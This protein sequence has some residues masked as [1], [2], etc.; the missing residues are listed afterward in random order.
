MF[1]IFFLQVI[2]KIVLKW[3]G[4]I[5][6]MYKCFCHCLFI[7]ATNC[8]NLKFEIEQSP[9]SPYRGL[10]TPTFHASWPALDDFI[11]YIHNTVSK[12][13]RLSCREPSHSLRPSWSP[14]SC[15]P[16]PDDSAFKNPSVHPSTGTFCH[17]MPWLPLP[18]NK[19]RLHTSFH[20]HSAIVSASIRCL[21]K[22]TRSFFWKCFL[23]RFLLNQLIAV[24]S[25]F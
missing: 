22:Y 14:F 12:I 16:I 9:T 2:Y 6:S 21:S 8:V 10:I 1:K 23:W 19:H 15:P 20:T 25:S 5:W 4:R 17:H 3:P 18:C 13:S 7:N 11:P 24:A